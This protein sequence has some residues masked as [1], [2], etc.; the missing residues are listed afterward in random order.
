[1]ADAKL[2]KEDV[3]MQI[4]DNYF[5]GNTLLGKRSELKNQL[6]DILMQS[7]Y[8]RVPPHTRPTVID[9][10]KEG[11]PQDKLNDRQYAY[12]TSIPMQ[13]DDLNNNV[14]HQ[15][16]DLIEHRP[17][18]NHSHNSMN[19]SCIDRQ[20]RRMPN[21]D[22]SLIKTLVIVIVL[23]GIIYLFLNMIFRDHVSRQMIPGD[24]NLPGTLDIEPNQ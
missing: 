16:V 7:D 24:M 18:R 8:D 1:M 2:K 4:Q 6:N 9:K 20:R 15:N 13:D 5:N 19:E 14:P 21:E 10:L 3:N 11:D 17:I 23:V 22:W 12:E